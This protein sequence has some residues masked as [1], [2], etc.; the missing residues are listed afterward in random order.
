MIGCGVRGTRTAGVLEGMLWVAKSLIIGKK[1][2]PCSTVK[3]QLGSTD[4]ISRFDTSGFIL[5]HYVDGDL[6]NCT[7][8]TKMSQASPDGLHVWGKSRESNFLLIKLSSLCF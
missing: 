4:I 3:L 6:V 2:L 7:S 1:V 8:E 5:E